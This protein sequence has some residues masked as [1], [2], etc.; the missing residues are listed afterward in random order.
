M[1]LAGITYRLDTEEM[2]I[3]EANRACEAEWEACE[4]HEDNPEAMVAE[5]A[6]AMA[7]KHP[8]LDWAGWAHWH[9]EGAAAYKAEEEA[10][11]EAARADN[12][13]KLAAFEARVAAGE[14]PH[15]GTWAYTATVM[16]LTSDTDDDT[17]WDR[18]KDE[19]KEGC[20]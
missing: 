13:E 17:D 8:G 11:R 4:V 15:P 16:A 18:W 1:K 20:L 10:K 5:T 14:G 7:A 6:A 9:T 3:E 19:M 2:P 12:A